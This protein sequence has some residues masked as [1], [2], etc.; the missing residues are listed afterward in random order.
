MKMRKMT[1][2]PEMASRSEAIFPCVNQWMCT[3]GNDHF[4]RIWE[5][6]IRY[7]RQGAFVSPGISTGDAWR[8]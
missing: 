4:Y 8:I 6:G 3:K 2:I 1:R 5:E 7:A